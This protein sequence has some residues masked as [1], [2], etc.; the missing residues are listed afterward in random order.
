MNV[1]NVPKGFL[2]LPVHL[3][4]I[5]HIEELEGKNGLLFTGQ[6][7][8][9][10]S[11]ATVCLRWAVLSGFRGCCGPKKA[12]SGLK[13]RSF[14]RAPLDLAPLPGGATAEFLAQNLDLAKAPPR[15]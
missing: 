5:G 9:T 3:T 15:L 6:L 4:R 14:G 13:M 1:T 7:R 12:I 2:Y 10:W 8:R 11:V